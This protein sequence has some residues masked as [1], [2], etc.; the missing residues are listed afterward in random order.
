MFNLSAAANAA[1]ASTEAFDT[2]TSLITLSML[3]PIEIA[4]QLTLMEFSLFTSIKAREFVDL[5]WMKDDKEIKAPGMLKMA[6]WSNHVV[7][8]IISEIVSV[9]D[10]LKKR[11]AVYEKFILVAQ[12]WCLYVLN[13][14]CIC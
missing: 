5:C 11:I 4:R 12:V 7:G 2:E 10:D 9:K 13:R 14:I 6:K 1:N 8:W 3:D